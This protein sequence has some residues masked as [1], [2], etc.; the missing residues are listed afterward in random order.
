METL[1]RIFTVIATNAPLWVWPLFIALV[2]LGLRATKQRQ[3]PVWVI[4]LLPLLGLLSLNIVIKMD[5][6]IVVWSMFAIGYFGGA[7]F[8]YAKQRQ[9]LIAKDNGRATVAG[10][11][12]TMATMMAIFC[13]NFV[14][15]TI[16][17]IVPEVYT[18]TGFIAVYVVLIALASGIFLGR[19]V[20][21]F[22]S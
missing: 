13:L 5:N 10:E 18:S 8:G 15:G 11:W 22:R 2:L 21:V 1:F 19:G 16:Q 4:Y 3:M 7:L 6:P 20:R 17:A 12:L 14:S 9:W